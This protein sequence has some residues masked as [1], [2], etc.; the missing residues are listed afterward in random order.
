MP[1]S[2]A[3]EFPLEKTPNY[4][5]SPQAPKLIHAMNS[6]IKLILTIREPVIRSV[7]DY[8]HLVQHHQI[9]KV[10]NGTHNVIKSMEAT[11]LM[12]NQT[13]VDPK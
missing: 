1:P 4:L 7:S 11:M 6:S 2:K 13:E 5:T 8:Q 9:P 3:D 10:W 12:E